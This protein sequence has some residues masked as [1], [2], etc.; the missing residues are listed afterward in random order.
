LGLQ[1]STD[2]LIEEYV[3]AIIAQDQAIQECNAKRGN[4]EYDKNIGV[5]EDLVKGGKLESLLHLLNHGHPRVRCVSATDLLGIAEGQ[6]TRVLE[7][8]AETEH[9]FVRL[10]A[11]MVLEEWRAGNLTSPRERST[12]QNEPTISPEYQKI[13]D[14]AQSIKTYRINGEDYDRIPYGKEAEEWGAADF[15][16]HDCEASQGQLHVPGCDTE[17]CPRCGGQALGCECEYAP[18]YLWRYYPDS[19]S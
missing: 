16:C 15:P 6:A 5:L 18:Y 4:A 17:Q 9:G 14:D 2:E 8:I 3:R 19:D 7:N 1:V 13:L 11:E 10:E 12:E